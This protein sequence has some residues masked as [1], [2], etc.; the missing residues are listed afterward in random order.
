MRYSA[1]GGNAAVTVLDLTTNVAATYKGHK[2]R[3]LSI[4]PPTRECPF[5]I[6]AD[7]SGAI[8]MWPLPARLARVVGT[9]SSPLHTA[10]FYD[11]D[12]RLAATTFGP[13][14]TTLSA[15]GLGAAGPHD[16]YNVVLQR[17]DDGSAL[18]AYGFNEHI[19]LWSLPAMTRTSSIETNQGTISQLRFAAGG[20]DVIAAGHDGRLVR[21]TPSGD[22][23][24]LA[25]VAQPI[26]AFAEEEKKEREANVVTAE[27]LDTLIRNKLGGVKSTGHGKFKN[28]DPAGK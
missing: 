14:V 12:T 26:V 7:A 11:G 18:A 19:E 13:E 27:A 10:V 25:Q 15:A 23:V 16:I 3:L 1:G 28:A 21:W 8:R 24:V 2:F 4:A 22:A 9:T 6:S 20:H 5:V 17:S